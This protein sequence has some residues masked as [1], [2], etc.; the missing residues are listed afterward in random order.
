MRKR[1]KRPQ[2]MLAALLVTL[3]G[4]MGWPFLRRPAPEPVYQDKGLHLWLQEYYEKRCRTVQAI[5]AMANSYNGDYWMAPRLRKL[6]DI[7][8]RVERS[9]RQGFNNRAPKP[10][11]PLGASANMLLNR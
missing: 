3:V 5:H 1:R 11:R 7:A 9:K 4:L 2:L 6:A 10:F 8:D